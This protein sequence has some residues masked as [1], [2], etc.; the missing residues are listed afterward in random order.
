MPV[1]GLALR[2]YFNRYKEGAIDL[3]DVRTRPRCTSYAKSWGFRGNLMALM[4]ILLVVEV[5]LLLA[6]RWGQ[7]HVT[8]RIADLSPQLVTFNGGSFDL[9]VLRYRALNVHGTDRLLETASV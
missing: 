9:P 1:P 2:P 4:R 3:C 5:A 7:V 6:V 8:H